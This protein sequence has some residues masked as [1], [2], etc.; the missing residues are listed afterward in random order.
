[1]VRNFQDQIAAVIKV[2]EAGRAVFASRHRWIPDLV[3]YTGLSP[4]SIETSFHRHLEL[5]PEVYH[6]EAL[7]SS[8][9]QASQIYVVLASTV[10]TAPLRALAS[11]YAAAPYVMIRPSRWEPVFASAIVEMMQDP[12]LRITSEIP[13]EKIQS[14]EVHVYGHTETVNAIRR[15]SPPHVY[16]R[17]YGTGIGIAVIPFFA[18]VVCREEMANALA[19]DICAFDQRGCLSPRIAFVE[20]GVEQLHS[21][22][23]ALH[24]ALIQYALK[25]P[26]GELSVQEE[27]ECTEY[28]ITLRFLGKVW[29]GKEHLIGTVE[30]PTVSLFLAPPGRCIHLMPLEHLAQFPTRIAPL[31]SLVL[32]IG[33]PDP[34]AIRALV[35]PWIRLA[36]LG[37]I[38]SPPLD[39]PV[40]RR[41]PSIQ[42][43]PLLSNCPSADF[44]NMLCV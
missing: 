17:G 12:H 4:E 32:T 5:Y 10:F 39:G 30:D 21:F 11:A 23:D 15:R 43:P 2:V 26:R 22:A 27:Q 31:F 19:Q 24:N 20:G 14:G 42:Y 1:M 36:K 35:P 18:D 6:L 3:R 9:Q 8:V 40:D 38:Q 7:V 37:K 29:K 13:F 16:V 28:E 25:V 44:L 33:S 41:P 34:D